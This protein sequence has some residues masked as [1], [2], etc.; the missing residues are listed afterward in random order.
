MASAEAVDYAIETVGSSSGVDLGGTG[1]HAVHL[2][3]HSPR[4]IAPV[5]TYADV[6]VGVFDD[7][8]RAEEALTAFRR[9]GFSRGDLGL[10]VWMGPVIVQENAFAR[11]D[12][13]DRGLGT[14]I[15]ELGVPAREAQQYEREFA[16]GRSIVAVKCPGRARD[17]A[18][19]LRRAQA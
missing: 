3:A 9:K 12:A 14:V 16:L 4:Q 18:N 6:A 19:L 7:W 5:R 2:P 10:A 11:A 8:E 17:A 13:A 15:G 1:S